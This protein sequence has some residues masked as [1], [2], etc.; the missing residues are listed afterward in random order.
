MN[1]FID[2]G[3]WVAI[4]DR[5][6]QYATD[7]S[8]LYKTLIF[9]RDQLITS[10]LVLVETYN[11]LS[12]TIGSKDTISFGNKLKLIPFLKIVPIIVSDWEK[13]WKILEKYN[14]KNFSFTDCTSFALM[15]RLKIR[16]AFSFD[17]HFTQYGFTRI[18]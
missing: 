13:A 14:D 1:L 10:D 16:T 9:K 5:N 17:A 11:L 15:E 4:A 8:E 2:T 6:D 12:Q 7:A 3:A 18:P